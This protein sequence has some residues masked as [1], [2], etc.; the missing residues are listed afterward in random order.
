MNLF[1]CSIPRK[2]EKYERI[3]DTPQ[4]TAIKSPLFTA[5]LTLFR[6]N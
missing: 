3:E 6:E 1:D 2:T 5:K 4:V